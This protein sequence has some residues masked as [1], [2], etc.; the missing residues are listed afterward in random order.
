[1]PILTSSKEGI[2]I[3]I[4]TKAGGIQSKLRS[5]LASIKRDKIVPGHVKKKIRNAYDFLQMIINVCMAA[6]RDWQ[7][8]ERMTIAAPL[9]QN[10]V[11]EDLARLEKDEDK[12]IKLVR[13]ISAAVYSDRKTHDFL[14]VNHL[15]LYL[16]LKGFMFHCIKAMLELKAEEEGLEVAIAGIEKRFK[17][18]AEAVIAK[19]FPHII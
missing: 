14:K 3:E 8:L 12:I 2:F 1:M 16:G 15:N 18:N 10:K 17:Y 11:F 6:G 5:L 9:G 19:H 7:E 13:E 4:H